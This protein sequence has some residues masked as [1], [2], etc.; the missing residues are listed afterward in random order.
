MQ[1]KV[2]T[3]TLNSS[4]MTQEN[5]EEIPI[6]YCVWDNMIDV[7]FLVKSSKEFFL[8]KV[9]QKVIFIDCL[10]GQSLCYHNAL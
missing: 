5:R 8:D 1:Y 10:K 7:I 9:K 2:E 6:L 3:I 4:I